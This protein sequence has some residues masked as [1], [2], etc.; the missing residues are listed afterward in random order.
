MKHAT[1]QARLSSTIASLLMTAQR[2]AC[3]AR[4]SPAHDRLMEK[5]DR[6]KKREQL[7]FWKRELLP[8]SLPISETWSVSPD[9]RKPGAQGWHTGSDRRAR[10]NRINYRYITNCRNKI[11]HVSPSRVK[12]YVPS[13]ECMLQGI[14]RR[15]TATVP[16]SEYPGG[17]ASMGRL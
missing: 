2:H 14:E 16:L 12:T 4:T 3:R 15:T 9:F 6:A 17:Q 1:C 5:R 8:I 10:R 11:P 13:A 7:P